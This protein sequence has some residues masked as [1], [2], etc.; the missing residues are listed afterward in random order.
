MKF[1]D[2]KLPSNRNFGFFFGAIFVLISGYFYLHGKNYYSITAFLLASSFA[3]LAIAKP[4]I[5]K[6][7]NVLW[8]FLGYIIGKIVSP[9]ILGIIFFGMFT[10]IAL[11]TRLFGRDELL[12]AKQKKTSYWKLRSNEDRE[13]CSF[14][15][16]F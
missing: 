11:L 3:I 5:L 12:L 13:I 15:N 4:K 10:P 14:K 2:I 16:Q 1:E 6:P 7:L 8:M 9:L